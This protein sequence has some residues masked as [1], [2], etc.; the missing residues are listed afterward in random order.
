MKPVNF[1][2]LAGIYRALEYAAFGRDLERARFGL[3]PALSACRSILVLGEGDGRCLERLAGIAPLARIDSVD[4]SRAMVERAERRLRGI[5]GRERVRLICADVFS[6]ELPAAEYDAVVTCFFL[7]CFSNGEV[8]A[9]IEKVQAG[10]RPGASWLWADFVLPAGGWARR[11]ARLW[12]AVLY[13]FFRWQTGLR[14]RE[15]PESER[16]LRE[17]GWEAG[18]IREF[19]NGMIRSVL[20][21]R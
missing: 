1:D 9:V 20:F 17:A 16:L 7:D 18:P 8:A 5:S 11:R 2:R 13:A 19:Q 14:T 6:H 21:R 4:S 3:L 10:V 15:L 12:L